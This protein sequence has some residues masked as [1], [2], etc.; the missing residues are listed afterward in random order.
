MLGA[1]RE[2]RSIHEHQKG[3]KK[4]VSK[5]RLGN[6]SKSDFRHNHNFTKPEEKRICF[7]NRITSITQPIS[8]RTAEYVTRL[9]CPEL[10]EGLGGV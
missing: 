5:R 1:E 3:N 2:M 6:S 8:L 9:A 7:S 10:V 4:E